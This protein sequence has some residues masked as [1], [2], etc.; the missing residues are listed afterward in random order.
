MSRAAARL[1]AESCIFVLK[2]ESRM[3]VLKALR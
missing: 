1:G 3:D 2:D